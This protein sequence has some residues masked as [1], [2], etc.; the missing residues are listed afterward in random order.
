MGAPDSADETQADSK[1]AESD[2]AAAVGEWPEPAPRWGLMVSAVMWL[3]W[4]VFLIWMMVL[5][6]QQSGA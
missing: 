6:I 5:R 2:S 3:G 4:V 1:S